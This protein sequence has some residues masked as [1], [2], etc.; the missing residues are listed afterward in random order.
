MPTNF[1]FTKISEEV[2]LRKLIILNERKATGPDR[3]S[4]KLLQ[5]VAPAIFPG[6]RQIVNDYRPV[7]VIPVIAK[8]FESIVHHQLYGYFEEHGILRRSRLVF[9]QIDKPRMSF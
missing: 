7:S 2:V 8:V 5:M 1:R 9:D 4:A 3:I 6:D